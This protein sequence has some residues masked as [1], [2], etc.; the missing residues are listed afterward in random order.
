[1]KITGEL[2]GLE[3][4]A[5]KFMLEDNEITLI[6]EM[7]FTSDFFAPRE[8]FDFVYG[9]TTSGRNIV[10]IDVS[11][12]KRSNIAVAGWAI[13]KSNVEPDDLKRFDA[14]SFSGKCIDVSYSS[15]NAFKWEEN[16]E[17]L[18]DDPKR[19]RIP[20]LVTREFSQYGK[21]FDVEIEGVKIHIKFDVSIR[22]NLKSIG[23]ATPIMQFQFS[24]RQDIK[25]L[26]K[27]YLYAFDLMQFFSFR[28]NIPFDKILLKKK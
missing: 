8:K 12:Q 25:K 18:W 26:P 24:E 16:A 6:R 15:Q 5:I 20:S 22:Y 7:N 4:E 28:R 10:F 13:S 2:F 14:I 3:D 21:G 23:E 9:E 17:E 27:F 11:Y 19:K 1:M